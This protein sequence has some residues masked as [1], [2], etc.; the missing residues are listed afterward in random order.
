MFDCVHLHLKLICLK[1]A[2]NANYA[3]FLKEAMQ[4]DIGHVTGPGCNVTQAMKFDLDHA[5]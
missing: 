3:E 1:I 4:C 2:D 5:M